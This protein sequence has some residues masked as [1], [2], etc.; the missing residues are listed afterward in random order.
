VGL[1]S[2]NSSHQVHEVVLVGG[3]TR[4]PK[5]QELLSGYF[6]GKKLNS[7]INPDEAVALG[8]ATQG[9]ILTGEQTQDMVL[10]DVAPLSLGI[11]VG[12]NNTIHLIVWLELFCF[13]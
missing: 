10:L 7:G 1:F 11:E 3:S 6:N 12:F 4:I 5:V 9:A 8:A 13:S 2:T